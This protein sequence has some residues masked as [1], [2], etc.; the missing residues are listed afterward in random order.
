MELKNT[1]KKHRQEKGLTQ[2]ELATMLGME[3]CWKFEFFN[4]YN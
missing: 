1:L 3:S 4:G 2:E